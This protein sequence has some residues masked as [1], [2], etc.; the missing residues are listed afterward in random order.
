MGE[1]R[2]FVGQALYENL[3]YKTIA[4]LLEIPEGTVKSRMYHA[5]K[6]LAEALT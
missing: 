4:H 5:K 6:K 2:W 1:A 3:P